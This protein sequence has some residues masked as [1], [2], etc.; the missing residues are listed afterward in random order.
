MPNLAQS[1]E[2]CQ[3]PVINKCYFNDKKVLFR[4]QPICHDSSKFVV[5]PM[6]Q[7]NHVYMYVGQTSLIHILQ[8]LN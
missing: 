1:I 6:H 2:T 4:F 5:Q 7:S 8:A 3:V